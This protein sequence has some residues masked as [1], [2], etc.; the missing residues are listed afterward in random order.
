MDLSFIESPT[1]PDSPRWDTATNRHV[2]HL[3]GGDM[4]VFCQSRD[5]EIFHLN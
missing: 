1:A 2:N 5:V 3:I 4:E